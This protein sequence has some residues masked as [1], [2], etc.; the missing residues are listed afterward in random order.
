MIE[1]KEVKLAVI[2]SA[3]III[4]LIANVIN[5]IVFSRIKKMKKNTIFKYLFY[6]TLIDIG[7]LLIAATDSLTTFCFSFSLRLI[8]NM[9]C[10]IHTFLTYFLTHMNSLIL[11]IVSID[12]VMIICQKNNTDRIRI[13][14]QLDLYLKSKIS[15]LFEKVRNC[16]PYLI[17]FLVIINLHFMIL[18]TINKINHHDSNKTLFIENNKENFNIFNTS[19]FNFEESFENRSTYILMC[20]PLKNE[21]YYIFLLN[22]WVWID[23]FIYSL[24]PFV[25]MTICSIIIISEIETKSKGF[26]KSCDNVN[27]KSQ[28]HRICLKSKRRNRKLSIMLLVNNLFFILCS[29]PY[30]LNLIFYNHDG[31]KDHTSTF[32]VYFYALPYLINSFNFIFYYIFSTEYRELIKLILFVRKNILNQDLHIESIRPKL[33]SLMR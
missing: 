9:S 3:I 18:L 28:N 14:Q 27:K 29:L 21:K 23:S 25:V 20:Y 8:S 26:L 10:K 5:L 13:Q 24:I 33:N 12:R 22:I 1:T 32:Q 7:V 2:L 15:S 4:G 11:M 30:R 31:E 19:K 6:L 16:V 17:L